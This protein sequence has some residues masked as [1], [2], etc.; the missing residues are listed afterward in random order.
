MLLLNMHRPSLIR[1]FLLTLLILES[2]AE[3][4]LY[5]LRKPYLDSSSSSNF[6][7]SNSIDHLTSQ[8]RTLWAG[9]GRGLAR[10]SNGGRTWESFAGIP[11][12]ASPGIFSIDVLG[13]VIW[14]ATGYDQEV[15][16]QS[17]QTGTGYA[18]SR[19]NGATW[20][21]S[22]QPLDAPDDSIVAY[23]ANKVSFLPITVPEQNVTFDLVQANNVIWIASWSSGLRK[24]TNNGGTW[25]R[26]VLPPSS[27]DSIAPTDSLNNFRI[28]PRKDYNYLA[29]S[30][31]VQDSTTI[32]VGTAGGINKSTDGGVS[33]K[34]FSQDN[35]AQ[36]ILGDWVVA[37]SAQQLG[38]KTRVWTTNWPTN[39]PNQRFG[40]SYTDDGG[41]S[42]KNFLVGRRAYG[43]AF[44]DSI[45]Y[46]A[47]D[48]GMYR[49]ADG[50]LSWMRSGTIIDPT[51][52]QRIASSKFFAVALIGDTVYG[53][54][55][56][57]LAK[58]PDSGQTLFGSDWQVIRTYVPLK[59][60]ATSYAYPNPFSP[61]NEVVR[62]HYS[63]GTVPAMVS[64]ELFDFGMNRVRTL[65][66]DVS[67]SGEEDEIWNGRTDNGLTVSN[68]AYFYRVTMGGDEP[69]WGKIVVLQ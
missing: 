27:R 33:W 62:I 3:A 35:Q 24:S 13:N 46:V 34:R 40:V 38:T 43:F 2:S 44:S 61:Q 64:I 67:R 58:T 54:T 5:N 53:G 20:T 48:D 4:Q 22:P 23:G 37:I 30:V 56:D 59:S 39:K 11:Q 31:M 1:H 69:V 12:F 68:G 6:P 57:G 50:G 9:T 55:A 29:F 17:V 51:T 36:P 19:D 18:Y 26:T 42:W 7:P 14:A 60:R 16:D 28:D 41:E 15:N 66:K 49:T 10:T 25:L 45:T 32:W 21:F 63:T 8:G 47:T 65:V 52:N